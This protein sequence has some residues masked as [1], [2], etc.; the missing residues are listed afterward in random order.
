M[1]GCLCLGWSQRNGGSPACQDTCL[2]RLQDHFFCAFLCTQIIRGRLSAFFVGLPEYTFMFLEPVHHEDPH[3]RKAGWIEVICGSM[4]SGKTEEL[5]RRVNRA[6]IAQQ[7]VII[8]KPAMDTRYD[9]VQVVSHNRNAVLSKPVQQVS[10]ILEQAEGYDVI[11]ID[12][13]QFLEEGLIEV[14]MQLANAGRRVIVTGLDM[15]FRGK[16]FGIMP[17]LMSVAEYVTKLHA[18]C[19]RCGGLASFSFRLVESD[20]KVLLGEKGEYE[21]RCRTCFVEGIAAQET[22]ENSLNVARH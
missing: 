11:A 2:Y 1:A 18:I 8:F 7:R 14:C 9:E 22:I 21:A 3:P 17:A 6:V 5:I 16:P 13:A 19:M 12:E 20:A 15:D 10:E 4:F